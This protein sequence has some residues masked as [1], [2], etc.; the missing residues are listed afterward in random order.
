M[1]PLALGTLSHTGEIL[2]RLLS[3]HTIHCRKTRNLQLEFFVNVGFLSY[4]RPLLFFRM[5]MKPMKAIR[6]KA[7]TPSTPPTIKPRGTLSFEESTGDV[8]AERVV[9]T[10][11]TVWGRRYGASVDDV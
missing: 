7:R 3:T 5:N 11:D 10:E 4:E 8:V 6:I 1:P 2:N 9:V